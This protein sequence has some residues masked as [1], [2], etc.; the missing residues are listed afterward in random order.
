MKKDPLL[1]ILIVL[2]FFILNKAV[3]NQNAS[4]KHV[5]HLVDL[6]FLNCE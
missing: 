1:K 2:T 6:I 3:M 4:S 5:I